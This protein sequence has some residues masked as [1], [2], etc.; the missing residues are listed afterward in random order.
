MK[1]SD[2]KKERKR[3]KERKK[4]RRV[5]S[6]WQSPLFKI[7]FQMFKTP[8]R[9]FEKNV[10]FDVQKLMEKS[11]RCRVRRAVFKGQ[12]E[13]SEPQEGLCRKDNTRI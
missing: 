1:K 13:R 11:G 10:F 6:S 7:F 5:S 8:R 12:H 9:T 3:K 4:E 2:G